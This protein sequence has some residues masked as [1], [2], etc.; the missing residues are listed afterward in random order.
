VN[1]L[2]RKEIG[3]E[4]RRRRNLRETVIIASGETKD[5]EDEKPDDYFTPA[6]RFSSL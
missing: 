5:D 6:G 1:G 4:V 3:F 2:R